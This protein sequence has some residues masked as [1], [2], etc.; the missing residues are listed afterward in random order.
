M[1]KKSL[2]RDAWDRLIHNN[3]FLLACHQNPDGDA[4]GSALALAHVLKAHGKDVAVVCEGGMAESYRFIPEQETVQESTQRRD[5]DVGMLIDC[6]GLRRA[7]SVADAVAS[8]RI[9]ACIDHHIPDDQ[10]GEIR[11]VDPE[12][13]STAELVLRLL[14]ENDVPVD[15]TVA[16][17]L[18][19]GLVND[20]GAFRFANTKPQ[21]FRAA[22][23]LTELGASP[24]AIAREV[25]ET[26]P[27]NGLRLLGRV[28][29]SLELACDGK[30]VWACIRKSDLTELGTTD[31]DTD[32]IVN[33]VGY[34][35][36]TVVAMLFRQVGE[37]EV[38]VS[39]RSRD[40]F[41]VNRVARA[42]DG[43]GHSAAAGC[44]LKMPIESA[45]KAVLDEVAKWMEC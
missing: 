29:S 22:A 12:A 34:A 8:A 30:V 21:T 9:G 1:K 33:Y 39:L 3:S 42:F 14:E 32:G 19:I 44:T 5:F 18:M 6:E 36:G 41:D 31:S 13:A 16:T 38:R 45:C 17:Q 28:L 27:V 25:Y 23:R 7:G 40:G 43:G 20:T 11:V 4:L 24:S 37:S 2:L 15:Q 26:R 35:Q 10:F